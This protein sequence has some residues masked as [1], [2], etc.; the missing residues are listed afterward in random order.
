VLCGSTRTTNLTFSSAVL[1]RHCIGCCFE[2]T[3]G[4]VG[5]ADTDPGEA[6]PGGHAEGDLVV[7]GE[8][9]GDCDLEGAGVDLRVFTILLV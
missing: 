7:D 6:E 8:A 1:R 2:D 5:D 4:L 3:L 9:E